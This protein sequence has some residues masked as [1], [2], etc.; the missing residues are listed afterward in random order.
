MDIQTLLA[1][2]YNQAMADRKAGRSDS[3]AQLIAAAASR[4][5]TD[6]EVRL[7]AAESMLLDQK[8][9]KGALDALATLEPSAQLR[10]R[11]GMLQ[12]DAFE[13]LGQKDAAIA[14]LQALVS[15][16]PNARVQQRIDQLQGKTPAP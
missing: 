11:K 5:N 2:Y 1:G 3:A 16:A 12:A 10:I 14:V 7:L 9:P 15:Q 13:A 4:Y 8:N 6:P